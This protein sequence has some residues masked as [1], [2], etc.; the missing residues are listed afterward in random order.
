MAG[1]N[2]T[3]H[4]RTNGL[5]ANPPQKGRTVLVTGGAGYIGSVLTGRLLE[6]GYNVRL[7]DRL[8]WGEGPLAAY[9]G[10]IDLIEADVREI[11]GHALDDV[12]G[13]IHLAGLS[14]DPTAEY[15]PEANWQMNAVATEALGRACVR[16][17]VERLV[18]ASSCSLYDGL[19]PG[20]HDETAPV[21]PAGAYATSKR[22]GE[23]ALLALVDEGLCPVILRNGTVYGFS[24]RMRYDLV[25]NTF[26]KDALLQE[27][28]LLHGGGWMWRPLVDVRDV[29]D[30]MIAAL[31]APDD[32]VRGEIF[33]VLHSNYQIRELAMLVAGSVQLL[34]RGVRLEEVPAPRL[35]RDYECSN[36]KLS[37]K[38]GFTPCRSVVEAVS[39]MLTSIDVS[40]RSTLTDPRY[41]N[42]RWL[43]LMQRSRRGSSASAPCSELR[44]Y[45]AV[46]GIGATIITAALSLP[47]S[48]DVRNAEELAARAHDPD[49][50]GKTFL[51]R[52]GRYGPIDLTVSASGDRDLPRISR[53]APGPRADGDE[54]HQWDPARAAA[55]RRRNRHPAGKE[56]TA[57]IV[58][59]DLGGFTG[60]ALNCATGRAN[61]DQGQ[62]HPRLTPG[63]LGLGL[64]LR[65]SRL[66]ARRWRSPISGS[67]A[68]GSSAWGTTGWRSEGSTGCSCRGTRSAVWTSSLAREL[69]PIRCSSGR[70]RAA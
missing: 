20:M 9:D 29:S 32:V 66:V 49:S 54:R 10:R 70:A 58:G 31:E 2:G 19:P 4:G 67:S 1:S 5:P 51:V 42:I 34:G 21:V 36:A 22:Y 12:Y 60:A 24:P 28:L 23:E 47:A 68:T 27:R 62:P 13:V 11:P 39:H 14:N 50:S 16:S 26:V 43:E 45:R 33:N 63:G 40:D 53:R 64:R 35:T 7:L 52:G 3:Y 65:H 41:Y 15:D 57:Q 59:N 25:V 38:L 44:W 48:G 61:P 46:I 17:G 55:V 18:F 8:Y 37:Q 6:R 56:R 30:A 69:T